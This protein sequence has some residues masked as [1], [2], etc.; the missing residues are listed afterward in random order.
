MLLFVGFVFRGCGASALYESTGAEHLPAPRHLLCQGAV[1][2][3]KHFPGS[4]LYFSTTLSWFF[5]FVAFCP[6]WS[7]IFISPL[8][9]PK[10]KLPFRQVPE[11]GL[12]SRSST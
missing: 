8:W 11:R 1:K 2:S 9:V 10:A 6:G 12:E 3:G 7:N 4:R 5:N